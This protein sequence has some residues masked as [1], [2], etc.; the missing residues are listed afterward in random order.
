M[1]GPLMERLKRLKYLSACSDGLLE[2]AVRYGIIRH[3]ARGEAIY[4]Q[5]AEPKAA[6]LIVNGIV[7][8]ESTQ[9]EA[10][11]I[12]HSRAFSGD[13]VGLANVTSRIVP[14]MHSAI[15][16]DSS[17]IMAFD[18]PRLAL[19]RAHQEFSSYLLQ[20][21]G[22]EQLSEEEARLNHLS[23]S[24]SYDKLIQFFAVEMSRLRKRGILGI[25]PIHVVGTQQ[26][27]ADAIGITRETVSRDLRPLLAK[28]IIARAHG[29]RPIGYSI[30][31]ER[32]LEDL[33]ASPL[34]RSTLYDN[35]RSIRLHRRFS[36]VA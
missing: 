3:Y 35:V 2:T 34:K 33:A 17:D 20:V 8:R 36:D 31:N 18:L 4:L 29:I 6:Y 11:V 10:V 12:Q 5:E 32:E 1:S 28:K 14:Y 15:A 19:L 13:W 16:A 30:L 21:I 25:H 22:K 9:Q 7:N 26:Y 24:R 23:A 27:I